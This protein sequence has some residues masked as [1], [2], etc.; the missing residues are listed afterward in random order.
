VITALR[1]DDR[2]LREAYARVAHT[3]VADMRDRLAEPGDRDRQAWPTFDAYRHMIMASQRHSRA[4]DRRLLWKREAEM[5]ECGWRFG[6]ARFR[7]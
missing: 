1:L 6:G 4:N 2:P 3:T 5:L 7:G